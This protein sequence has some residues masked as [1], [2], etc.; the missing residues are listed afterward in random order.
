VKVPVKAID[1]DGGQW[2]ERDVALPS[3]NRRALVDPT[4][5]Q[6]HNGTWIDGTRFPTVF[7]VASDVPLV[8]DGYVNVWSSGYNLELE[9][10]S[11]AKSKRSIR[12]HA[13]DCSQPGTEAVCALPVQ[14]TPWTGWA[15]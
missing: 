8:L 3:L 9:T 7:V 13:V 5:P 2:I 1:D 12:F 15:E 6:V 14:T 4:F 11:T 10:S